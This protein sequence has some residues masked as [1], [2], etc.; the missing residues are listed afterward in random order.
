MQTHDDERGA[1][2]YE[3][4]FA[5]CNDDIL[6]IYKTALAAM[7]QT[8]EEVKRISADLCDGIIPKKEAVNIIYKLAFMRDTFLRARTEL[9]SEKYENI[10]DIPAGIINQFSRDEVEKSK[11]ISFVKKFDGTSSYATYERFVG[12]LSVI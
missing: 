9:T 1:A 3:I 5:E 11:A 8:Y 6:S 2:L 12:L 4:F 7:C 10:L